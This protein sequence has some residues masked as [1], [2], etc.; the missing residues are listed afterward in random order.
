MSPGWVGFICGLFLG[1]TLGVM[2]LAMFVSG[3]TE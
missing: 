2:S 3:K 1:F